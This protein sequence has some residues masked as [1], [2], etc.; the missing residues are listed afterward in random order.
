MYKKRGVCYLSGGSA[1]TGSSVG[2]F[3]AEVSSMII[4]RLE[5]AAT[6]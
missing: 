3:I 5:R 1:C 6:P 4:S 2:G